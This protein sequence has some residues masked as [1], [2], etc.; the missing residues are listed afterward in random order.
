M[1]HRGLTFGIFI[2]I[3]ST[4]LAHFSKYECLLEIAYLYVNLVW[5][6]QLCNT[7][8]TYIVCIVCIVSWSTV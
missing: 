5:I 7:T 1:R 3:G 4:S 2:P 6:Y 8:F